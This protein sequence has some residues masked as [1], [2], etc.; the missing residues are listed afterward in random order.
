MVRECFNI[1]LYIYKVHAIY[2][3]HIYNV[4]YTWTLGAPCKGPFLFRTPSSK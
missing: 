4:I 2:N 3:S 1:S